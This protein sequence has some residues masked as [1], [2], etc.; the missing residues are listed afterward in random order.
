VPKQ[1]SARR[2]PPF[3]IRVPKGFP[4]KLRLATARETGRRGK[5]VTA[6]KLLDELLTGLL[7]QVA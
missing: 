1:R 4:K 2:P 7:Q 3:S 6:G 5:V